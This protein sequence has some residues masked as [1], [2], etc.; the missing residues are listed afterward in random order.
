MKEELGDTSTFDLNPIEEDYEALIESFKA[1]IQQYKVGRLDQSF[2][3][4]IYVKIGNQNIAVKELAEIAPKNANTVVL[5]PYDNDNLD[6]IHKGVQAAD[7]GFQL[8][9][10]EKTIVVNQ[11]PNSM[12][13][14]KEKMSQRL[15]KATEAKRE[16]FNNVRVSARDELKKYKK[17]VS[18]D[19]IK[20]I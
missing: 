13:E 4:N 14:L 3:Q 16:K 1:E 6:A 2:F 5:N 8:T 19:R 9:R 10:V 20:Q 18:E 12:K 17:V 7:L 15:K 11:P